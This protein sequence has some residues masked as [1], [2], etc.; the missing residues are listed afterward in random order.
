M[1]NGYSLPRFAHVAEAHVRGRVVL[2]LVALFGLPTAAFAVGPTT[3]NISGNTLTATAAA[4]QENSITVGNSGGISIGDTRPSGAGV[5]IAA[6]QLAAGCVSASNGD[7]ARCPLGTLTAAVVNMN[8]LDDVAFVLNDDVVV[9]VNGGAGDDDLR[10][11]PGPDSLHGDAGDDALRGGPAADTLDGGTGT[12]AEVDTVDYGSAG[13]NTQVI[14]DGAAN[15]GQD[16]DAITA[17]IQ[18]EGDNVTNTEIVEGSSTTTSSRGAPT[19]T[20]STGTPGTMT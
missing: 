3:V 9:T 2:A 17:G 8:D 15:D 11:G 5:T 4:G 12:E 19:L 13:A 20:P 14:L 7:E 18:P 6:G 16:T 1:G 10:G